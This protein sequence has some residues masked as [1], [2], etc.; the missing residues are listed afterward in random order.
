MVVVRCCQK[1]DAAEGIRSCSKFLHVAMPE[2][3]D[4]NGF[5]KCLS[6]SLHLLG[7]QNQANVLSVIEKPSL[8]GGGTDGASVNVFQQNG[9]RVYIEGALPWR[10]W[11]WCYAHCLELACKDGINSMLFKDIE[12]LLLR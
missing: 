4:A 8:V 7:I 5:I 2:K 1:D 12:Q 3:A 11:S 9:M 10:V 6:H